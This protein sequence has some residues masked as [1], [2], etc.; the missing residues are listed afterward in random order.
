[1]I[2]AAFAKHLDAQLAAL[3]FSET[4]NGGNVFLNYEPPSPDVA[5]TIS[6]RPGIAEDSFDL[7]GGQPGLHVL[8]RGAAHTER[9]THELAR[10]IYSSLDHL[11]GVTLDDGG[12][13]EVFVVGC[14]AQQSEP[15]PLGRD[16][17]QRPRY[18]LNFLA[19][20]N[21]PTTNRP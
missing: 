2:A 19:R 7:P 11:D 4:G 10:S 12:T 14:T 20:I 3:T 18:S 9:A 16:D 8:V 15:I 6:G 13:D 21:T 5:V 17:N 1:M